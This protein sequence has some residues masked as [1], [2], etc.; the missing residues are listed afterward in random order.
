MHQLLA[1][2]C[3]WPLASL[4]P[5]LLG[6]L[7]AL[8]KRRRVPPIQGLPIQGMVHGGQQPIS[9][10]H[11]YLLAANT[12]ANAGPGIAASANNQSSSLLNPTLTG[13][14]DSIGGYVLTN[15]SGGF[16]ITGDYGCTQNTQVYVYVLGGNPGVGGGANS[17]A[18]LMA[19]LGNCPSGGNFLSSIPF[20]M[21]N[22]ISTV[23]AAYSFAGFA[24]DA[25]H[26]STSGSALAKVGIANAFA[27]AANLVG[28]S[29]GLALATTPAGNGTVPQAEINTLANILAACVNSTGPGSQSC[30][31][32]LPNAMNGSITPTDTATAAINIAHNPAANLTNLYGLSTGSPP[33]APALTAQPT[34]F[35]VALSFTGGGL[36]DPFS[37]AVDGNGNVWTANQGNNTV[38]QI[39]GVT[40]AAISP[41]GG[42]TGNGLTI[43]FAIA[44]DPS[45]NA[46]VNNMYPSTPPSHV[47]VFTPGGGDV[48]GIAVQRRRALDSEQ[49]QCDEPPGCC[50]RREWQRMVREPQRYCHGTE[51]IDGREAISPSAGF[52]ISEPQPHS[53]SGVAVDSAGHVWISGM[54][55]NVLY[56][57]KTMSNGAL[58]GASAYTA[59]GLEQP[60]S[61]A[62]D[63]SND[64]WL[65]NNYDP[66]TLVGTTVSKVHI[67]DDW[68][69]IQ[70]RRNCGAGWGGHRRRRECVGLESDQVR[71][72]DTTAGVAETE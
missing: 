70:R 2:F 18:G 65:P 37:I 29:T 44:I 61:I 1:Q 12:L 36:S 50:V 24:T 27:N 46:W 43:P 62:I 14:G 69:S 64:I 72:G 8:H 35:T 40:G 67:R 45:G 9:G 25:T 7:F 49:L 10:A 71:P 19:A 21:V 30:G 6:W 63:A 47:S 20:I 39:N 38:S 54:N 3:V 16:T 5:V 4:I 11:V 52:P 34:E 48:Y 59:G 17:A 22:E 23:A 56:E 32:L 66:N 51:W 68:R 53:E 57:M 31:T 13:N 58:L 28:I 15:S 55:G 60:Y 42:Y 26:V 33:F 41:A